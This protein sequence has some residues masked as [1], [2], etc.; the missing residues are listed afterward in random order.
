MVLYLHSYYIT[1]PFSLIADITVM[2]IFN[3]DLLLLTHLKS[4]EVD[5]I[6]LIAV[7]HLLKKFMF[8]ITLQYEHTNQ[9]SNQ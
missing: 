8:M 5:L 2:S 7:W 6:T 4:G 3:A 1:F 9:G